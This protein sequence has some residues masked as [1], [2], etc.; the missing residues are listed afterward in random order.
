MRQIY[1][2]LQD[3]IE[4]KILGA[5]MVSIF[6]QSLEQS[7]EKILVHVLIEKKISPD[8]RKKLVDI[9]RKFDQQIIFH[10]DSE[11]I[12]E[13]VFIDTNKFAL[14]ENFSSYFVKTPFCENA[15]K[16]FENILNDRAA[17]FDA[18]K[19]STAD[20]FSHIQKILQLTITR[21]RVFFVSRADANDVKDTFGLNKKTAAID[22]EL[23]NSMNDLV[24]AMKKSN[25]SSNQKSIYYLHIEPERYSEVK[26]QLESKGFIEYEDFFNSKSIF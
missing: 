3:D 1:Y 7:S 21:P 25:Q 22:S 6:E 19:K 15:I 14:D 16:A 26:Q 8:N 24:S 9:V 20:H 23:P 5:S 10:T 11:E 12:P 13:A 4:S 18:E 17:K 2:K